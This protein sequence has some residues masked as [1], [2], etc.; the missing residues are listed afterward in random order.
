MRRG[1]LLGLLAA[2]LLGGCAIGTR[3]NLDGT[4]EYVVGVSMSGD[5]SEIGAVGQAAAATARALVPGLPGELIAGVITTAVGAWG[6]WR[7]GVASSRKTE[8]EG[9]RKA[10]A[11]ADAAWDEA[12]ARASGSTKPINT[13]KAKG[14]PGR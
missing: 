9:E 6:L 11:A 8:A 2:L 7:H 1:R 12:E 4:T 3:P 13:R 14:K 5:G 10:K